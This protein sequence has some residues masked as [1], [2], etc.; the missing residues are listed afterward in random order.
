MPKKKVAAGI[1]NIE[2]TFNNTRLTLTDTRGNT[3]AWSSSGAL[4]FKGAKK[5]TPFAAAKIGEVIGEKA[6]SMGMK[7]VSV[8]V[9]GVGQGREAGIRAFVAKGIDIASIADR[10][11]VPHN[12]PSPRKPRRV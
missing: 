11:P 8:V 6:L 1:L 3:L 12:G 4:G 10:T 5:G 2:A 9:K 7:E